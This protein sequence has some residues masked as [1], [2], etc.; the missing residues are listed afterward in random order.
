MSEPVTQ[1]IPRRIRIDLMTPAELACRE[2]VVA[3]ERLPADT[4]LTKAQMLISEAQALVADFVDTE[5]AS[6]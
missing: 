6:V 4:R 5:L 2:A 1:N 3:I